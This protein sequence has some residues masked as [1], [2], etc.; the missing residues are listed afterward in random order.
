MDKRALS[1][2]PRPALTDKN[3]EMPLLVPNM[4]YLATAERREVSGTDTLIINFFRNNKT[5][6]K[7]EFRTFCQMEIL[8]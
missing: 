3:K 1:A 8:L 2:I 4:C 7:P 5:E 6:L